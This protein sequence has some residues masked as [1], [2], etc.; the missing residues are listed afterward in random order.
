MSYFTKD[1]SATLAPKESASA[2]IY[3]NPSSIEDGSTVRFAIL[4]ES[5]LEG[6][7]VWFTKNGG[8]MTKR[9]T[10]EWPDDQLLAELCAQV[11]GEVAERDGKRAIKR[12]ASFFIY[13]FDAEMVRVFSANQKS[14]LADIERLASDEDYADLSKWDLKL[15]RTGKGTDTRYHAAMVPTKRSTEKVAKAVIA[16]WDEACAN[17]A[18]LEALYEGGNPLPTKA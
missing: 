8:G 16:A 18:D 13:D 4:S 2:G 15:T 10:P 17:G 14:L 9:I 7:E 5:P 11:D 1:F 12:C 3:L 6:V